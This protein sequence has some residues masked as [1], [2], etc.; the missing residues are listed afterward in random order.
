M[1]SIDLSQWSEQELQ[2]ELQKR[3]QAQNQARRAYKDLVNSSLTENII[4]LKE[5]SDQIS[6]SK[7]FVF[8]SLK[9][10]LDIKNEVYS[11]KGDQQSHTFSDEKGNTITY[12]FRTIDNWDDTLN[13][14]IEKVR[15]FIGSLA[16]DENSAKLVNVINRLLRK[17]AKGNL[18]ASRVLELTK[19]AQEFQSEEFADAVQIIAQAYKP[20]QS[21]FFID[22][23]YTD[24]Q[25]K[26]V[27]IP[28]NI[29]S[30]DFPS[31]T[32]ITDLFP[33]HCKYNTF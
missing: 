32:N 9:T 4:R 21:A 12:G 23:N 25:G 8:Q 1:K 28:L 10:L 15:D 20:Q 6:Q 18:K 3:Q 16:K 19:I 29:S 7:L 26:K 2:A 11:A 31:G 22:A 13:V 27:N 14:G 5:L 30:V 17:D 33:V 24:A